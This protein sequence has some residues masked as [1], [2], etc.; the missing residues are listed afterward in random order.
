MT[1]F[2]FSII[3]FAAALHASWNAVVK[4]GTDKLLT[5]VLVT[6]VAALIAAIVLPFLHRPAKESWFFIGASIPI[7][8][9]YFALVAKTYH[10][11]DMGQ[12]YP[13]MRGSAPLIVAVTGAL[14]FGTVLMPTAWVGIAIICAG[15]ISMAVFTGKQNNNGAILALLNAAVI[16]SYTLVDGEGVRLS[17]SPV[18]Y[19]LWV[20]MLTGISL[21]A[22]MIFKRGAEIKCYFTAGSADG[23]RF[24]A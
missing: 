17:G 19:T 6:T 21:L 15:I 4:S 12:T 22:W 2:V 7:H 10:S 5:T 18:A 8:I 13:L 23:N 1:I 20:F 3:L 16:A 11:A 14:F 24:E 9:L